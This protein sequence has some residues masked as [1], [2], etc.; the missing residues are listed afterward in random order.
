M[1]LG[2]LYVLPQILD[3]LDEFPEIDVTLTQ[4]NRNVDLVEAH[5]DVAVRIGRLPDSSLIATRIGAFRPVVCASPALLEKR[6]IPGTPADLAD[7]PCVRFNG[8]MFSP[9]WSFRCPDTGRLAILPISPR[10]QVSSP[11]AAVDAA[12]RGLGFT[13]LLHYH[14][15]EAVDAGKLEIV[16]DSFEL[17]PVPIQL[18]HVSRNMIPLKLRRF[19][20][21]VTP[22]F[23]K[24]LSRFARQT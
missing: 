16:L 22:R 5:V 10:L 24:S 17:D 11:D 19:L 1:L 12:I 2:R 6:G 4:S 15:A 9:D 13:Q 18:V 21:F 20:D 14:V 3:F 7:M 8:P 23:R